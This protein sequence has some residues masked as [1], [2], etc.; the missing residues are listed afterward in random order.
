MSEKIEYKDIIENNMKVSDALPEDAES[1]LQINK[2][3]WLATYPNEELNIT[4]EDIEAKFKDMNSRLERWKNN[5]ERQSP[6]SH[7][8]K[9]EDSGRN[10]G[11]AAAKKESG[12]HELTSI[13]IL[14]QYQGRG[15]GYQLA[16]K[17]LDWLGDEEDIFINVAA[18]NSHA[19]EFYRKLGFV[20]S[21][22][23]ETSLVAQLP[24]GKVLPEITMIKKAKNTK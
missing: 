15:V 5:L 16:S 4:R 12:K 10:I 13:Y 21:S 20:E 8:W 24:N 19:I 22:E 7:F 18:Y 23:T 3:T 17:V 1:L 6:T 14:P 2:E 9:A 11:Y